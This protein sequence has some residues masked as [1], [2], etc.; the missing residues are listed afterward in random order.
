MKK[1]LVPI[2]LAAP[3]LVAVACAPRLAPAIPFP[4]L[5]PGTPGHAGNIDRIGI[6]QPSGIV[7]HPGRD[8]LFVVGDNGSIAEIHKDGTPVFSQPLTGDLEGITVDPATG[9]LYIIVEGDDIILEFDPER[10]TVL[11]RF[12]IDRDFGGD[13]QFLQKQRDRY[14]DGVEAIA[15]VPDPRHPEGGTFYIGNQWD[16][17]ALLEV[18]VRLRSRPDTPSRGRIIR[19]LPT[20]VV[21]PSDMYYDAETRR[22][23]VIC[24]TDNLLLE[25]TLSGRIVAQY[26]FPGDTQEGLAKDDEGFIYLAQD[27]GGIIKLKDLRAHPG[28]RMGSR[29]ERRLR[30]G[31]E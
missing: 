21:D 29:I 30:P 19:L 8:T 26:A 3:L 4:C 2:L 12:P 31:P 18:E 14:D 7:F 25:I 22:L 23:N 10:R 28:R 27:V 15:W 16:P 17:S 24:D 9:L 6:E 13:P 11:R 1:A 20:R 5:W